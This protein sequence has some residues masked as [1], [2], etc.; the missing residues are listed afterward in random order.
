MVRK[1]NQCQKCA[2]ILVTREGEREF[3]YCPHC[4][5][6]VGE[7]SNT[8]RYEIQLLDISQVKL[9]YEKAI[10]KRWARALIHTG[11]GSYLDS[12]YYFESLKSAQSVMPNAIKWPHG[13]IYNENWEKV[14]EA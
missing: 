14:G 3:K 7:D 9:G 4:G 1:A 8:N 5:T 11:N 13:I 12:D 2:A 10:Q 6:P